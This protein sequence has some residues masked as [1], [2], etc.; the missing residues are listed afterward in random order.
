MK[1]A[2]PASALERSKAW[3]FENPAERWDIQW[4]VAAVP[5]IQPAG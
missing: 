5:A 2:E 4:Q 3:L 1:T